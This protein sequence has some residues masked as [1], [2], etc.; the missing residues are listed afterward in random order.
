MSLKDRIKEIFIENYLNERE[1][2]E[3]Q[4]LNAT[5]I[6]N[7]ILEYINILPIV[8]LK[9]LDLTLVFTTSQ[10]DYTAAFSKNI[11][12]I[13]INCYP[14]FQNE[15]KNRDYK[16]IYLKSK[17]S[18]IHE[19]I[20]YLD[21]MRINVEEQPDG[22][23]ITP[24]EF[25]A[26]FLSVSSEFYDLLNDIKNKNPNNLNSFYNTFGK[27]VNEFI[28]LVFNYIDS[29]NNDLK[30]AIDNDPKYKYKWNKRIYQLY[31]ELKDKF[32]NKIIK[33]DVNG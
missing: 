31:F 21:S 13:F 2:D 8:K 14:R 32:M 18:V 27:T 3:K 9:E 17:E 16:E 1:N 10:K 25:N 29:K 33:E 26:Y 4:I 5:E 24:K 11:N 6:Y 12:T 7:K 19:L 15:Y 28:K 23:Y 20:H 22:F 30:T